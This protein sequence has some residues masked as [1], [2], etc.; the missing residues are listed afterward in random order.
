MQLLSRSEG[1]HQRREEERNSDDELE[2]QSR[3][4]FDSIRK[5]LERFL[6][7]R[8]PTLFPGQLRHL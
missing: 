4:D 8:L 7:I 6:R 3:A 1:N 5:R 2:R